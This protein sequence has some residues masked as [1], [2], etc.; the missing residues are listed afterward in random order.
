MVSLLNFIEFSERISELN[1]LEPGDYVTHIDHGVGIFKGLT[2]IEVNGAKQEAIKL[3]Y[4]ERDTV[5]L[6]V[7]LFHKI[8]KYN[9]KDG[10]KPR[11]YKLGSGAWDK[12]KNKAKLAKCV[13]WKG[14][15]RWCCDNG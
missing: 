9:S 12:L 13:K 1:K 4:G 6:S 10:T 11:I 15:F 7:H 3:N 14:K 2:K 8:S 5:Y